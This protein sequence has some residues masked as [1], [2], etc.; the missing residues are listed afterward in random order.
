MVGEVAESVSNRKLVEPFPKTVVGA[1]AVL[2]DSFGR[3]EGDGAPVVDNDDGVGVEAAGDG[4]NVIGAD[5]RMAS[6]I[7]PVAM[8]AV[9]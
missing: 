6:D 7:V 1:L 9:V 2:R 3:F 4:R 5:G 8:G